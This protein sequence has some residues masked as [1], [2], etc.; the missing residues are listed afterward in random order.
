MCATI[1]LE[2]GVSL[3]KISAMLGHTSIHTTFE[4]YCE[5]MDEKEKILAFMNNL[6]SIEDGVEYVG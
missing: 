3:A 2:E 6:F 5:G 1:L 4:Y